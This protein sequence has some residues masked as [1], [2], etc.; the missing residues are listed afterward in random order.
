MSRTDKPVDRSDN[1]QQLIKNYY[2]DQ[3]LPSLNAVNKIR[4][5]ILH[6]SD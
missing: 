3:R 6:M 5:T 4:G 1:R 2:H